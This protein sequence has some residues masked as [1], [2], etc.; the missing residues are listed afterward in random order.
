MNNC[1]IYPVA[2]LITN[3]LTAPEDMQSFINDYQTQ[4]GPVKQPFNWL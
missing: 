4:W 2:M 1:V 3:Y